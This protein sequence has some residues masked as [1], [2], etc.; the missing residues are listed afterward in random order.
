MDR[1]V[2]TLLMACLL[3]I[4]GSLVI[5]WQTREGTRVR[6]RKMSSVFSAI[7]DYTSRR[8]LPAVVTLDNVEQ[9]WRVALYPYLI[10]DH[11]AAYYDTTKPF[12]SSKNLRAVQMKAA[13]G[14]AFGGCY[15]TSA[16]Q[17]AL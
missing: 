12:D 8:D 15:N 1:I 16:C 13:S 3:V 5:Y 7:Q 4:I 2:K 9:S 11:F 10:N 14:R 6:L 17:W